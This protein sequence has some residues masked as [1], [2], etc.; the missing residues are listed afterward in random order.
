MEEQQVNKGILL[1]IISMDDTV[2]VILVYTAVGVV[3]SFSIIP[4]LL[5]YTFKPISSAY[6]RTNRSPTE[7]TVARPSRRVLAVYQKY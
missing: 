5:L 6:G 2:H 3:T 4:I 1:Y 7:E